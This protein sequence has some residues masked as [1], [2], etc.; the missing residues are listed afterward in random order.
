MGVVT[1]GVVEGISRFR[2][3]KELDPIKLPS[4]FDVVGKIF[5]LIGNLPI[6]SLYLLTRSR[7]PSRFTEM[8]VTAPIFE[9]LGLRYLFQEKCLRA[10]PRKVVG[11]SLADSLS[12][13]IARVVLS[14]LC[15]AAM[16]SIAHE[17]L[18]D[19]NPHGGAALPFLFTLG[20]ICG[21]AQEVTHRVSAPIY[22]HAINNILTA[23]ITGA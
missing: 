3:L 21:T 6:V 23:L 17:K 5:Y 20:V 19:E 2:P 9:E 1:Y 18:G 22:I 10:L 4:L 8:C 7:F 12:A 15:F 16:H 11:E 14:A 13:R